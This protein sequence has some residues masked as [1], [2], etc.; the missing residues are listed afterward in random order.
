MRRE[1]E[2]YHKILGC[3][4][5]PI[6]R[7]IERWMKLEETP[8]EHGKHWNHVLLERGNHIGCGTQKVALVVEFLLQPPPQCEL[9]P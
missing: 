9:L 2:S 1:T 5:A 6:P 7:V 4:E 3:L 8:L